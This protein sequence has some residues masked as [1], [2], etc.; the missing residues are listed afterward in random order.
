[1]SY[2]NVISAPGGT[3]ITFAIDNLRDDDGVPITAIS[4]AEYVR[5]VLLDRDGAVASTT[6]LVYE[7]DRWEADA[8]L[9]LTAG[10]YTA[11]YSVKAGGANRE[12]DEPI[13]VTPRKIPA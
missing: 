7:T 8:D 9:P 6:A 10:R 5:V 4:G 3:T 13:Y 12:W 1:M 2:E 11:V